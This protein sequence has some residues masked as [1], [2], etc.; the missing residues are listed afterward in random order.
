MW[1]DEAVKLLL[2]LE[3]QYRS[4][5]EPVFPKRSQSACAR[6][7]SNSKR[8]GWGRTRKSTMLASSKYGHWTKMNSIEWVRMIW[9]RCRFTQYSRSSK[10]THWRSCSR[11]STWV[12]TQCLLLYRLY[13]LCTYFSASKK[14]T[15]HK[16]HVKSTFHMRA[17]YSL[18]NMSFTV[19]STF[20]SLCTR[21]W[22]C[23]W[24]IW[25]LDHQPRCPLLIVILSFHLSL[26]ST[27]H[28]WRNTRNAK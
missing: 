23:C 4:V 3:G 1:M 6:L 19:A 18:V 11:S 25:Y 2:Q 7:L 22:R 8:L 24:L 21:H 17:I 20:S 13:R 16:C 12:E 27:S 9:M 15:I 14:E 10:I 5:I 26:N 28:P